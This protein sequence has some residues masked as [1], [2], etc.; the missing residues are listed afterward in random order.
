MPPKKGRKSM[1]AHINASTLTPSRRSPRVPPSSKSITESA[2]SSKTLA[3]PAATPSENT[4]NFRYYN[5]N[6]PS[7]SH[8]SRPST[9]EAPSTRRRAFQSRPSRLSTVHTPAADTPS[10]SQGS[11]MTRRMTALET[12]NNQLSDNEIPD[13]VET[14]SWSYNQYMGDLGLNGTTDDPT[15]PTS[16]SSLGTRS[17]RV[18]KPTMRA[19]EALESGQKKA[20]VKRSRLSSPSKDTMQRMA[21]A[22]AAKN[23]KNARRSKKT[24]NLDKAQKP[25]RKG[26]NINVDVAGKKMYELVVL[27]LTSDIELPSAPTQFFAEKRSEFERQQLEAL[28]NDDPTSGD[29][30]MNEGVA[31][32]V[33]EE[34][35]EEVAEEVDSTGTHAFQ[36]YAKKSSPQIDADGWTHTGRVNE[37]GEEIVLMPPHHNPYRSPHTYVDENLPMPP[38]RA[39]SDL[40]AQ[41]DD[42]MGYPP[43]LGDRNIP[44]DVQSQFLCEDVSEQKTR[45]QVRD[46]ARRNRARSIDT[47]AITKKPRARKRR[48]AESAT[49]EV[50]AAPPHRNANQNGDC[51]SK[52]RRHTE[53]EPTA[54]SVTTPSPKTSTTKAAKKAKQSE[55]AQVTPGE[56]KKPKVQRL[57]L[58]LKPADDEPEAP[59]EEPPA[60]KPLAVT[61]AK[62]RGAV[63]ENEAEPKRQRVAFKPEA[64]GP[65]PNHRQRAATTTP[66]GAK[67][68]KQEADAAVEPKKALNS[69]KKPASAKGDKGQKSGERK[70]NGKAD[71]SPKRRQGVS[72]PATPNPESDAVAKG[73]GRASS[74]PTGRRGRRAN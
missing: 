17:A 44:F 33:P 7:T 37:H 70:A 12:P 28:N 3:M 64:E 63:M 68:K 15:S 65:V 39:R 38:V 67:G 42:A 1:P 21:S 41:R 58:T 56:D 18:R 60:K 36:K 8:R 29:V 52:R 40:Q 25:V 23:A 54:T 10:S 20:R 32:N 26:A 27:A 50:D 72:K 2:Q 46:E 19:M 73:R 35:A 14:T 49:A 22:R 59:T 51:K 31:D 11:R 61:K 71:A 4:S 55:Q 9:P 74:V 62:K 24:K 69:E 6:S 16:A 30:E 45:A 57:R 34:V 43:L 5:P 66:T 13:S 47:P 53:P 48:L